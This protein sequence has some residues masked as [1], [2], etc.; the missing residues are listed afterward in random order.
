MITLVGSI[1]K[2]E[3]PV[4][5][6]DRHVEYRI[7]A[8]V[9]PH[10]AIRRIEVRSR[11]FNHHECGEEE[12]WQAVVGHLL[13]ASGRMMWR[14]TFGRPACKDLKNGC[15]GIGYT[16]KPG[17]L[18]GVVSRQCSQAEC[19]L[20]DDQFASYWKDVQITVPARQHEKIP[21]KYLGFFIPDVD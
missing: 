10:D 9:K 15:M 21:S 6:G 20:R 8:S 7:F 16:I 19:R 1:E 4:H 13:V 14:A 18:G 2:R 5:P 11:R 17:P 12:A 3:E